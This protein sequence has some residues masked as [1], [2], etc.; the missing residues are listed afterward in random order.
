[1]W[2]GNGVFEV[3]TKI[4]KENHQFYSNIHP[5]R[6]SMSL[7]LPLFLPFSF[8]SIKI[9]SGFN[10]Y[11]SSEE[12]YGKVNSLYFTLVFI[13]FLILQS[14]RHTH[15]SF[16]VLRPLLSGEAFAHSTYHCVCFIIVLCCESRERL[17]RFLIHEQQS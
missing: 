5:H 11:Q 7:P 3:K 9:Q 16:P 10:L 15:T 14:V 1:M 17:F 13:A 8:S 4:G 12:K 2:K 6:L